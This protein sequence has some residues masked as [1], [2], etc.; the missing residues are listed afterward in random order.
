MLRFQV[1]TAQHNDDDAL[2]RSGVIESGGARS[3]LSGN[4]SHETHHGNSRLNRTLFYMWSSRSFSPFSAMTWRMNSARLMIVIYSDIC[5]RQLTEAADQ[6]ER[7]IQGSA[8]CLN[9]NRGNPKPATHGVRSVIIDRQV[10][11]RRQQ[12]PP[13]EAVQTIPS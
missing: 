3:L 11:K 12:H 1:Q 4:C 5:A 10:I 8:A 7:L 2:E 6:E 13:L 9:E